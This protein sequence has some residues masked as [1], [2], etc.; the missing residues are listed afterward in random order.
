[1]ISLSIFWFI[2]YGIL[3]SKNNHLDDEINERFSRLSASLS[4]SLGLLGAF[5]IIIS[6]LKV[7]NFPILII[8]FLSLFAYLTIYRINL[9]KYFKDSNFIGLLKFKKSL[10]EKAIFKSIVILVILIFLVSIGPINHA[11]VVNVYAGYPYLFFKWNRHFVDSGL[12]Q[13]LLG[14]GDYANIIFF[15]EKTTWLIRSIQILSLPILV[16]FLL[17]NANKFSLFIILTSP[18]FIQWAT[19]GKAPF[20]GDSCVALTYLAWKKRNDFDGQYLKLLFIASLMNIGFKVSGILILFPIAIDVIAYN[21]KSIFISYKD[22]FFHFLKTMKSIIFDPLIILT[23][24]LFI[25]LLADRYFVT[26][27]I[28]YPFLS[29][30]FSPENVEQINFEKMLFNYRRESF[31]FLFLII[32]KNLGYVSSIIGP[33]SAFV[34][35]RTL[36]RRF[37]FSKKNINQSPGLFVAFFQILLLTLIGQGRADYYAT[38]LIIICNSSI[39]CIQNLN[40][41]FKNLFESYF[42]LT[43]LISCFIQ[44]LIFCLILIYSFYINIFS[45][46]NYEKAMSVYS[47]NYAPTK[48]IESNYDSPYVNLLSTTRYFINQDY[49]EQKKFR[50]CLAKEKDSKVSLFDCAKAYKIKTIAL[51]EEYNENRFGLKCDNFYINLA[52]RN[53]FFRKK[54]KISVCKVN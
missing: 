40:I 20:L 12:N 53:P 46:F 34:I 25:T 10:G 13:G 18:V 9:F 23:V 43:F 22:N 52:S 3:S 42:K 4:I 1:M 35:F 8:S 31:F 39:S 2:F 14:L 11:D 26:G 7:T 37:S 30:F 29:S 28:F 21:K 5:G 44:F 51:G 45:L 32:P 17:K 6:R 49:V 24:I 19:R 15:Q 33:A 16:V 38:P 27:N 47:F 54:S 36:F 41:N 48:I 50:R